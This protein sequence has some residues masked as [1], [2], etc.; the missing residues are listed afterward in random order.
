MPSVTQE[1]GPPPRSGP[2]RGRISPIPGPGSRARAARVD[3][4]PHRRP[5]R[6]RSATSQTRSPNGWR[7]NSKVQARPRYVDHAID[8]G[9]G[10][11]HPDPASARRA[12]RGR[13]PPAARRPDPDPRRLQVR[14]RRLAAHARLRL[15]APQRPSETAQ[16]Q[17]LFPLLSAQD[18]CHRG[19][20]PRLPPRVNVRGSPPLAGFQP[21]TIGRFWASTEG[22]AASAFAN[23]ASSWSGSRALQ[24]S[25]T[26]MWPDPC[27]MMGAVA[28]LD[29]QVVDDGH[30]G[31][32]CVRPSPRCSGGWSPLPSRNFIAQPIETVRSSLQLSPRLR[33]PSRGSLK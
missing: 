32:S 14:A 11:V 13:L 5:L 17:N 27:S 23:F 30:R 25:M 9:A 4:I 26:L 33:G 6:G 22:T 21:S 10:D 15:D 18:V 20:R 8:D 28:F 24:T 16:C 2:P 1:G 7:S 29:V 3:G 19:G 12:I 31:P